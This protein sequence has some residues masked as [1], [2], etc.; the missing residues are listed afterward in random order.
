MPICR[1][2]SIVCI[3]CIMHNIFLQVDIETILR[4]IGIIKP[5]NMLFWVLTFP[6]S[7][8]SSIFTRKSLPLILKIKTK[9]IKDNMNILYNRLSTTEI[10]MDINTKVLQIKFCR[11]F[12]WVKES[13]RE[14]KGQNLFNVLV[15]A[16]SECRP[17]YDQITW[18][19]ASSQS[20]RISPAQATDTNNCPGWLALFGHI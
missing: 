3:I 20:A 1:S 7:W 16:Q 14:N 12:V 5:R 11:N 4:S 19:T 8:G 6:W 15:L 9:A 17:P 18:P 10:D 2:C 13:W